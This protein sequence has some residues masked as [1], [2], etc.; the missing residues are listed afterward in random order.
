MCSAQKEIEM[1]YI[2]KDEEEIIPDI[3]CQ[4]SKNPLAVAEYVEEI[5]NFY[6]KCEVNN[7]LIRNIVLFFYSTLIPL[8]CFSL[9]M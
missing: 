6:R 1:E 4:D 5:Y 2:S 8:L 9:L 3:D 7:I